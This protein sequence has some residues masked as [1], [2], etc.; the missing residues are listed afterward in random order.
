MREIAPRRHPLRQRGTPLQ[1]LLGDR[2]SPPTP[3]RDTPEGAGPRISHKAFPWIPRIPTCLALEP[4]PGLGLS[5]DIFIRPT[6]PRCRT[7]AKT[8]L[9]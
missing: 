6:V 1:A 2:G 7:P 3:G 9:K 5:A 4:I 8:A